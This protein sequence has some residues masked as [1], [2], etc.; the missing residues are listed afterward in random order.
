MDAKS[1]AKKLL[2]A[3]PA[4][5]RVLI[6]DKKGEALA[7]VYSETYPKK[8]R[9]GSETEQKLGAKDMLTFA[10]FEQAEGNYGTIDFILLAFKDA[11]VML[12]RNEKQGFNVAARILRSANAEYLH[13]KLD[14]ILNKS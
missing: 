7:H 4:I 10:M 14:P 3:D 6:L 5:L 8:A 2:A 13:T 12:M 1:L 9:L 11:K